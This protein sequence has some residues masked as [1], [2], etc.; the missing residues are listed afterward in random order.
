MYNEKVKKSKLGGIKNG[1]NSR[2]FT[3]GSRRNRKRKT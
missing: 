1:I 3:S 2:E